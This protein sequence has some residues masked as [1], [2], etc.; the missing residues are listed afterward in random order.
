M[1]VLARWRWLWPGWRAR[2]PVVPVVRLSGVIGGPSLRIKDTIV[3]ALVVFASIAVGAIIGF[4]GWGGMGALIGRDPETGEWGWGTAG[5]AWLETGKSLIA[6]DMWAEDP[7]RAAVQ[8][9]QGQA[10]HRRSSPSPVS[11]S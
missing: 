8:L 3:Q 9:V 10:A 5:D 7:A 1:S 11:G 4:I 2:V 6:W